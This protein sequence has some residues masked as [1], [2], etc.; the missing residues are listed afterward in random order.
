MTDEEIPKDT[1]QR[2]FPELEDMYLLLKRHSKM[3]EQETYTED[4]IVKFE[5]T[6]DKEIIKVC[7][8]GKLVTGKGS[9]IRKASIFSKATL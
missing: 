6:R 4:S 3:S 1:I 9:E 5:N 8:K 7:S 2:N